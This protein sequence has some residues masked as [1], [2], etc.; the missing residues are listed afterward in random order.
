MD[1]APLRICWIS[2]NVAT[3]FV[4]H[5]LRESE[6]GEYPPRLTPGVA[7]PHQQLGVEFVFEVGDRL[8]HRRLRNVQAFG[9]TAE[10]ALLYH[11]AEHP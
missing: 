11:G 8:A 5:G 10:A 3:F 1:N 7:L 4:D 9:G 2:S 6:Q